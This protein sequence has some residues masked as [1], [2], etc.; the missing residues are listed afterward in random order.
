MCQPVETVW[1]NKIRTMLRC[2]S[3]YIEMYIT[4]IVQKK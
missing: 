3:F 2:R 1:G 4:K